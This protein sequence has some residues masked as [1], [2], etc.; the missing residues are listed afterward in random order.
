MISTRSHASFRPQEALRQQIGWLCQFVRF[1]AL[2]YAAWTLFIITSVWLDEAQVTTLYGRMFRID[3]SGITG[4]QRLAGLSIHFGIWLLVAASVYSAWRLFSGYLAG[5]IFTLDAT[6][7]LRRTALFGL[8][9]QIADMITRP[10][11]TAIISLHLPKGSRLMAF[12]F[13]QID[14]VLLLLLTALV[15]LAHIF[16]SAAAIAEENEGIV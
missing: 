16:K 3:L 11:I 5:R 10:A 12:G 14:L 1:A 15:A 13:N 7:W 4:W 6:I 8:S 9:A 2:A